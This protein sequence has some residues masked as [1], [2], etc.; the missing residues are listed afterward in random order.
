MGTKQ[1]VP[2]K[3]GVYNY[4]HISRGVKTHG[5][6]NPEEIMYIFE[7]DLY[8]DEYHAIEDFL[9]W[10]HDN[11]KAFGHGNYEERWAEFRAQYTPPE[12]EPI[13]DIED[14]KPV[15]IETPPPPL[16]KRKDESFYKRR[17]EPYDAELLAKQTKDSIPDR[18]IHLKGGVVI[19]M[20][21]IGFVKHLR[22]LLTDDAYEVTF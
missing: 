4:S 18:Q 9:Q 16:N 14:V 7:E 22:T 2:K 13:P 21:S 3:L 20:N 19:T 17:G 5:T 6:C 10:C 12:R 1:K 15:L 11:D 8:L